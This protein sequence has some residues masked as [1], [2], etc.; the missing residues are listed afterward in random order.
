MML[1]LSMGMSTAVAR[2]GFMK[3]SFC[4][5]PDPVKVFK[6]CLFG[7]NLNLFKLVEV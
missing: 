7:S 5:P 2:K 6:G 3:Y 1:D 4:S